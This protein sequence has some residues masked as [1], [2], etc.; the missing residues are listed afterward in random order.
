MGLRQSIGKA[1]EE[2]RKPKEKTPGR[3][4]GKTHYKTQDEVAKASG[5][6]R[7]EFA[8]IEAGERMPSFSTLLKIAG[9]LEVSLIELLGK[10][11]YDGINSYSNPEENLEQHIKVEVSPTTSLYFRGDKALLKNKD[12]VTI[13]GK[14][15]PTEF[16][17]KACE[18]VTKCYVEKGYIIVSG[19][20]KGCDTIVQTTCIKHG[21]KSIAVLP[22]GLRNIHPKENEKLAEEIVK[23]GGLLLSNY[24]ENS[25]PRPPY[26]YE[27][28]KIQVNLGMGTILIESHLNG[29]E[30]K[31]GLYAIKEKGKLV[32]VD[33]PSEFENRA[34]GNMMLLKEHG[35]K[36]LALDDKS[37][38]EF[39]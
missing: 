8:K 1:I 36:V 38:E 26:Y 33:T 24:S 3:N 27:S 2:L 17:I 13:I 23:S 28:R 35:D 5:I 21:G 39:R 6:S 30:M 14:K 22:S 29:N 32:C 9:G 7:T 19:L 12:R 10:V 25:S 34:K 31:A 15:N 37:L 11:D 20:E 16:S 18:L 4:I